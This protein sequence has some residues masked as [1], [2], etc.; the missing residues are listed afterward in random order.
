LVLTNRGRTQ[1][2]VVELRRA[3]ALQPAMPETLLELGKATAAAGDPSAAEKLLREALDRQ[4]APDLA[5][6]AHFQLARIYRE[7]V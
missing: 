1:E 7:L 4:P 6:S 2:A 5:E 3:N